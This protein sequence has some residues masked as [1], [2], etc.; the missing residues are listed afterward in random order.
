MTQRSTYPPTESRRRRRRRMAS[1]LLAT[2]LAVPTGILAAAAPAAAALT[3]PAN[4][5]V[6]SG[7]VVIAEGRGATEDCVNAPSTVG[8]RLVVTRVADGAVVHT[9]SKSGTGSY[10]TTWNS[11]GAPLG[12]YRVQSYARDAKKSGFLNL[13]CTLQAERRLS[14]ITVTLENKASV[15]VALPDSVVT[16]EELAVTVRTTVSGSGVTGQALGGRHVVVTVPGVGDVAVDTDA[17][18]TGTATVDL[19]DLPA[20]DLKVEAAVESDSSYLGQAAS[21]STRVVVRS[22]QTVYRGASRAMPGGSAVLEGQLLDVT[23]GSDRYGQPVQDEPLALALGADVA[24]VRTVATGRAVRTVPVSGPSR[25]LAAS[26]VY[27]GGE[28]YGPSSDAITFYVSEDA[29]APAPTES[30]VIGNVTGALGGLVGGLLGGGTTSGG[31]TGLT[32]LLAALTGGAW[33]GTPLSSVTDV[34]DAGL[35]HV[36][37]ATQLRGVLD[38]LLG[39]VA[40]GVD[41][42]GDPVDRALDRILRTV[43]AGTPL[44]AVVDTARFQWRA[45]YVADDGTRRNRE[46]GAFVGAPAPLDVTGDG[47]ADV[48]A[49]VTLTGLDRAVADGDPSRVV[50]RLEVARLDGAPDRL[51][52]SLQA[53]ID[54]PDADQQY[55]FGYDAREG[56]APDAFRADVVL[57][58]GG[59]VLELTSRGAAPV[60]VTGAVV[61]TGQAEPAPEAGAP[62]EQRFAVGFDRAPA[63]ARIGLS[64]SGAGGSGQDLAASLE[65]DEP[66]RVTLHLADD[67]G[68]DRVFLADGVL[69]RVEGDLDLELTGTDAGGL[70]ASLTSPSGLASV[71]LGARELEAGRSVEDISLALTDVPTVVGFTLDSDGAGELTASGPIG[72]FEAGYASGRSIAE[73]DDP[74]YL[75]LLESGDARSIGLRLPGFEGMSLELEDEI[76]LD[77]TMAPTPLRALV[78]QDGLVLDARILDAPRSIG[79]GL[80]PD[81]AVRVTGSAPI[82]LVTVQA[83]DDGGILDGA[84]DLDL[85]LEDVPGQLEV[86]LDEGGTVRFDTGGQPVGLLELDAHAGDPVT[87]PDG[88][89]GLVLERS[90]TGTTIAARISGLR[91]VSAALG[92]APEL[93]LDTV[94]GQ[95]FEVS[96]RE[97]DGTGALNDEVRATLDHLV[98]HM[99]LGVVDDGSGAVS[100]RYSADEPTNSLTF[101]MGD[102]SGSIGG[103]LPAE[104]VVCM[105]GDEAC[106]PDLGID[107]PGLGSV[108][109]AAS[110]HTTVDLVDGAGGLSADGLR[111][112]VLELTGSLDAD[113]GGDVYLNTTEF[114]GECGSEGCVRPIRGGSVSADLGSAGLLFR[115]GNG[116]Y[117][118]D[119]LTRLK[120]RK[121]FGQTI[122]VEGT[123]GTGVVHCVSD[124]ALDVTVRVAGIPLTLGLEDAIC[125]VDRTP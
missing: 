117:A 47:T 63:G 113:D 38:H 73:L 16:G 34:V 89:D 23:P 107:D 71:S 2:S 9:A 96:L 125:D 108:R 48:L 70:A 65:V 74:A 95:V 10:S 56:D 75:R 7:K 18:G 44:G 67:S 94:A 118:H 52:L 5:A 35:L 103:P 104:L 97:R 116:F 36:L 78:D 122:G 68:G 14:D 21:A 77:L 91:A 114:G 120:P 19:P 46:F 82:D 12:R 112:R 49:N 13:G 62:A 115:P 31:S 124:T 29:A 69:D 90:P 121:L 6:V 17:A 79:L 85:R 102:L 30:G 24:D 86:A 8:S 83:S 88:A 66:T 3:G 40:D 100:L 11:V 61:P 57:A 101:D 15:A 92:D 84:T 26:A 64:L 53:L 51:P 81:G 59:A 1:A 33:N 119:A 98:P 50:P 37:D 93:M 28:V 54:L 123:G 105:A 58:E 41:R 43:G 4:G 109:F 110:E 39:A 99:R 20:G 25:T 87:V 22:T 60:E 80:S 45:S 106:L 76:A 32:G 72:V 42:S 55:R 27:R 111:V